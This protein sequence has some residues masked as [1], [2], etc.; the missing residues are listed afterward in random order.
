MGSEPDTAKRVATHCKI[1][2]LP[3]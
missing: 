2:H 3:F 1:G